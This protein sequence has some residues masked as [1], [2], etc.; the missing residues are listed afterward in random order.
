MLHKCDFSLWAREQDS[1][2]VEDRAF[3]CFAQATEGDF[4]VGKGKLDQTAEV[5]AYNWVYLRVNPND[6]ITVRYTCQKLGFKYDDL[7]DEEVD[8]LERKIEEAIR[9]YEC[10]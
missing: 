4:T 1:S 10:T 8:Y 6:M 2:F 3:S 9:N 5:L 7:L